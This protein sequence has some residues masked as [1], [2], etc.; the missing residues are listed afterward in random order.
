MANSRLTGRMTEKKIKKLLF[1]LLEL[2]WLL[3]RELDLNK[4]IT[5]YVDRLKIKLTQAFGKEPF[6][7]ADLFKPMITEI[8][9]DKIVD[10]SRIR[11]IE[12]NIDA[13]INELAEIYPVFAYELSGRYKIKERLESAESYFNEVTIFLENIPK[14]LTDWIHPKLSDELITEL[15]SYIIEISEKIDR[16]TKNKVSHKLSFKIDDNH[17]EI[18]RFIDEY[19]D[20]IKTIPN[21]L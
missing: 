21:N 4:E 1:N 2:R 19:I 15:D 9:K 14:E 12:S 6:E 7:D 13:T 3:K 17:Q 16:K 11:E 18:D 5:I 8:L 20:K 10:P